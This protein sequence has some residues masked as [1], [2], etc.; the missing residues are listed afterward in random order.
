M[1]GHDWA[2]LLALALILILVLPGLYRYRGRMNQ[3]LRHAA[4]WLTL[5]VV[6][7]LV[8]RYLPIT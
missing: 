3:A 6:L 1:E 5:A 4:I 7:A 2:R 8:W